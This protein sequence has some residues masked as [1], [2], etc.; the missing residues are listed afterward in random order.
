MVRHPAILLT[1]RLNSTSELGQD[2]L[3]CAPNLCGL[4]GRRARAMG[5]RGRTFMAMK[6]PPTYSSGSAPEPMQIDA[7]RARTEGRLDLQERER[8]TRLGLCFICAEKGHLSAGCPQRTEN[9]KTQ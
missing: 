1:G 6:V 9:V 3:L 5:E 2:V 4:L 8:R 7:A